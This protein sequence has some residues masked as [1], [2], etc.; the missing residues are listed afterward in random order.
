M[1]KQQISTR[2][3]NFGLFLEGLK[4]LRV[5]GAAVAILSIVLSAL[6][7]AV[8]WMEAGTLVRNVAKIQAN[9]LCYPLYIVTFL[10]PFFFMTLFSYLHKR[11]ESDFFHAIPYTRTCVYVS[12]AASAMFLVFAIQIVSACVSG[13]LW[14]VNPHTTFVLAELFSLMLICMLCALVLCGL[15]TLALTLTGTPLMTLLIFATMCLVPRFMM[16]YMS[17]MLV[18]NLDVLVSVPHYLN[19]SWFMPYA[20]LM[21]AL[22]GY[23]NG[24][25]SPLWS[26]ACIVYT[27]VISLLAFA[28]GWLFYKIR[29]SEMAGNTTPNRIMQ[30]IFRCLFTLPIVLLIPMFIYTGN[31]EFSLILVILV[32]SLLVYYLYELITTKRIK[33]LASATPWLLALVVCMAL[34]TTAYYAITSYFL[35]VEIKQEDVAYVSMVDFSSSGFDTYQQELL[36]GNT[37]TDDD[38]LIGRICQAYKL[39]QEGDKKG[40][41]ANVQEKDPNYQGHMKSFDVKFIMKNGKTFSRNIYV[42]S[43]QYSDIYNE[44]MDVVQVD[45]LVYDMP[46]KSRDLKSFWGNFYTYDSV[47]DRHIEDDLEISR[48]NAYDIYQIIYEEYQSLSLDEKKIVRDAEAFSDASKSFFSLIITM[49]STNYYYGTVSI[50]LCFD[51]ELMPKSFVALM[52]YTSIIDYYDKEVVTTLPN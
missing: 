17:V 31:D 9:A 16:M 29:K 3:F 27:L 46:Q 11:K 1:K 14:A 28:L 6:I 51:K 26:P 18:D 45:E 2:F 50:E 20:L 13:I 10:S 22:G 44:Y 35:D 36:K 43:N 37:K 34:F 15:M 49:P 4:R 7:P 24:G 48:D 42:T 30:H 32:I 21:F 33:N 25:Y 19:F 12:F 5:I 39:T 41:Y 38:E 8:Y 47:K 23:Q 52:D 40:N